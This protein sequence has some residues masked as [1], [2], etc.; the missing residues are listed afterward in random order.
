MRV[1]LITVA[2]VISLSLVLSACGSS[3]GGDNTSTLTTTSSNSTGS[4]TENT[5]STGSTTTTNSGS[6]TT[7]SSS[8]STSTSSSTTT[9]SSTTTTLDTSSAA[10]GDDCFNITL[11][12]VGTKVEM[13]QKTTTTSSNAELTTSSVN[14]VKGNTI[15]NGQ[16]VIEIGSDV[17]ATGSSPSKSTQ[18][19]YFTVDNANLIEYFHGSVINVTEPVATAGKTTLTMTPAL[20][21]RFALAVNQSTTQSYKSRTD[22]SVMGF[23]YSQTVDQTHTKQFLGLESVTVPAGTFKSCKFTETDTSTVAGNTTTNSSTHWVAV[24]SG[25]EVKAVAGDS[26]TQLL[27][28]KINGS[29]I[30]GQ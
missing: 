7:G 4:L 23:P 27:S 15:F 30:T 29:A 21:D 6:S 1:N 5:T 20:E 17:V 28:A 8:T 2:S 22:G 10:K 19:N 3:S 26:T 18:S 11:Y 12:S 9:N 14:T 25:I 16:T 24:G 13:T